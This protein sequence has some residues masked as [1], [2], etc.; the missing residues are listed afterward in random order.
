MKGHFR[1]W[2]GRITLGLALLAWSG[3]DEIGTAPR[4]VDSVTISPGNTTLVVGETVQLQVVARDAAGERIDGLVAAWSTQNGDVATVS[5]GGLL[6]AV[7][8]GATRITA[9]LGGVDGVMD[10]VVE[11]EDP[12]PTPGPVASVTLDRVEVSLE[13]GDVT[14]LVASAR[15]AAGAVV[16]G[17]VVQWTTSNVTVAQVG[18]FGAVTGVKVGSAQVT[19]R[20]DGATA[21]AD[22]TVTADYGYDLVYDLSEEVGVAPAL[23]R[24][25]IAEADA[26][27]APIFP[28]RRGA[29]AAVSPDGGRIAFRVYADEGSQIW[30]ADHDGSDSVKVAGEPGWILESPT[31]SPDGERI[32]YHAWSASELVTQIWMVNVDGTDP[33]RLTSEE[34]GGANQ[35]PAW[36]PERVGGDRIAYTRVA[37]GRAH[38]WTMR[39]DGSDK[40]QITVGN[41]ADMKPAWSP[42]GERL[43]FERYSDTAVSGGD[44]WLVHASGA[45]PTRL[46]SLALGEFDPAWSPDGK[47]IA[48][49]SGISSELQIYTIWTDGTKLARRTSG[50]RPHERPTWIFK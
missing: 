39:P 48:F 8:T 34:D 38:L 24:L 5:A 25:S 30:V 16:P 18:F 2:T 23:Y 7:A 9:G 4:V 31:W 49:S 17:R 43:A 35:W 45:S 41:V 37:D 46:T 12:A 22:V 1:A 42:D 27:P 26:A 40:T 6:T 29:D 50:E 19:A 21:T 15:D 20:V 36:S 10:V 11:G 33:V 47:L 32:A 13:E 14:T 3:C 44:V 28:G